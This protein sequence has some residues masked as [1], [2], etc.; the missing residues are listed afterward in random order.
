VNTLTCPSRHTATYPAADLGLADLAGGWHLTYVCAICEDTVVQ[1][2]CDGARE[3]YEAQG[4][5]RDPDEADIRARHATAVLGPITAEE[6]S[7][8]TFNGDQLHA[9]I[10]EAVR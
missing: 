5:R 8:F 10:T 4:V 1:R 3:D 2:I 7:S 9:W 6:L